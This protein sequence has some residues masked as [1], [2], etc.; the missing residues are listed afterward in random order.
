MRCG[1]TL[2]IQNYPDWDRFEALERGD[3]TPA[4][5]PNTDA[6]IWAEEI[7]TGVMIE[8]LGFDSLWA[9]EHHVTPY[10]MI[11]NAIQALTF[12]AGATKRIDMGTMVVVV[13]WHNPLRVA[14]E[15]TMLQHALRGRTA[16]IGFGRGLGRREF[17]AMGVDQNESRERFVE[18]VEII[19]LAI[20]NEKFSYQGRHFQYEDIIMRP[21]PRDAAALLENLHFSWGSP[22]SAPVGAGLG[23]KPMIIPQKAFS[24]YV[25]ELALYARA[26]AEAGCAPA[27][28]R[29]HL[30]MYCDKD[31]AK[32]EEG[33]RKYVPQYT[34]SAMR[35][36]ELKANH[37]QG[38]KGY[39]YY[40]KNAPQLTPQH[41]ADVWVQ[42]CVWGTPD[43]CIAKIQ[44]LCDVFH[45]EEFMLTGR[46]GAMPWAESRKSLELFAKEVLP[47]VREIPTLEPIGHA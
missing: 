6:Q 45:P 27:R 12:F 26:R 13:P 46:Y 9:V 31:P 18:S 42:N 38:L 17:K 23:L 34:D 3:E 20:A 25:E 1:V 24:E 33:A 14:E 29:I 28:P 8:E 7:D 30:H 4:L 22:S 47:A 21:R 15:M 32:A 5:E 39:E 36:Y 19:K 43:Q 35:N 40:A 16:F 44:T 2:Y 10:T 37:F 11:T 41:F